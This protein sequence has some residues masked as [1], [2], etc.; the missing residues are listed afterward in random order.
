MIAILTIV[1]ACKPIESAVERFG[2]PDAGLIVITKFNDAGDPVAGGG[3]RPG[4]R[5]DAAEPDASKRA[6]A[7]SLTW[8]CALCI[9]R[10]EVG[11]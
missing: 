8:H 9:T 11:R 7:R 5:V 10:R 3:C 6:Y 1:M 2:R 4:S